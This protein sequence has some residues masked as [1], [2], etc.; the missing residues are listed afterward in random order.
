VRPPYFLHAVTVFHPTSFHRRTCAARWKGRTFDRSARGLD[1]R[2]SETTDHRNDH[3]IGVVSRSYDLAIRGEFF[4]IIRVDVDDDCS[5][6]TMRWVFAMIIAA[7]LH[8][9]RCGANSAH[10]DTSLL[11]N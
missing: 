6:T 10:R 3:S 7:R 9:D 11:V 8:R 4:A 2:Y 5:R 1:L